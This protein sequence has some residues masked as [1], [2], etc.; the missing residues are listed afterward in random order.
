M[1][2]EELTVQISALPEI[3][4][5]ALIEGLADHIRRNDYCEIVRKTLDLSDV[6]GEI[7]DL[8]DEIEEIKG[9]HEKSEI[10]LMRLEE[11][12]SDAKPLLD[13]SFEDFTVEV[14]GE[15][16]ETINR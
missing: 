6:D 1:T 7:E 16:K 9:E 3:E 14:F 12:I 10:E 13:C 11:I 5:Q 4:F 2:T 8:Q 15:L